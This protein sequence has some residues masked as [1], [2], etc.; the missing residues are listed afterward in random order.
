MKTHVCGINEPRVEI[1]SC[2]NTHA[3][4]AAT[5]RQA[6]QSSSDVSGKSSDVFL[7]INIDVNVKYKCNYS[8]SF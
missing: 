7:A 4:P 1:D 6:V 8:N 2:V 5:T 3:D